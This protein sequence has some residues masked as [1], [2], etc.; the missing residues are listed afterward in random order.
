LLHIRPHWGLFLIGLP[1]FA[2]IFSVLYW[3][4]FLLL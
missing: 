4:S 1:L 3:D 2:P